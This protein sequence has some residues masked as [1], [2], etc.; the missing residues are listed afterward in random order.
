MCNRLNRFYGLGIWLPGC[1]YATAWPRRGRPGVVVDRLNRG[2]GSSCF[3][4][5]IHPQEHRQS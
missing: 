3:F 5:I 2:Q 1:S 4:K